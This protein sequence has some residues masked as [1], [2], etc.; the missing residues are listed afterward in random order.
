M[1]KYAHIFNHS[2]SLPLPSLLSPSAA[3]DLV[4]SPQV[5]EQTTYMEDRPMFMLQCAYEENC[6]STT[7]SK[8]PANSY[9]RLLRFSS[10]IHN[11][12]QSDFRPKAGRHSWVWHDC[13]RQVAPWPFLFI[14]EIE[15]YA[16][17]TQHVVSPRLCA[18]LSRLE[19]YYLFNMVIYTQFTVY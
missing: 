9:R 11:N 8:T 6:L 17:F 5:V 18:M 3:P 13:H 10:Q 2:L 1:M 7:S 14:C 16:L 4:L 15:R 12:G 19:L